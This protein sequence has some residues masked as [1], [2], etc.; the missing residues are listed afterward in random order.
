MKNLYLLFAVLGFAFAKAQVTTTPSTPTSQDQVTL[1]FDATGTALE[2]STVDLYAHTGLNINGTRW[3]NVVGTWNMNSTQPKFTSLGNNMYELQLGTS[4]ETFYAVQPG[5]IVSEICLVIRNADASAQTSPDIFLPVFQPGLNVL[6]TAPQ[7]G[8][9]FSDGQTVTLSGDASVSSSMT[10][11]VNGNQVA[12]ANAATVSTSY[13]FNGSGNYS[14]EVS[15]DDG[16]TQV[17]DQI[18]VFVPAA[19]QNAPL[20]AGLQNGVNENADGSVTFVLAAPLKSDVNLLAS[21]NSYTLDA[22]NQMFK[23]GDYFWLTVPASDVPAGQEF[24]YQYLV[25]FD[26]RVADPYS[27][28]ILDPS[29]DNE[30]PAGNFPNL[31]AYPTNTTGDLSLYTPGAVPYNWQNN[32]FQKPDQENLVI[33]ELLVRDFSEEDSFQEVINRLDYLETLGINAIQFMPLNE[34]ENND[35][36]GYNPKLHGAL[37]KVYGTPTKFKELVD[38]CHGRGIAVI[39]DVVYNHAYSQSPLAQMWWDEVAFKPTADNPYL[40]EDPKHDFNVGYDFNHESSFTREYVKQTLMYWIDEYRIDGFR[41]DLS[42]GFT[43]NNTLGNVGAWNQYDQSRVDILN[44]YRTH[45]WNNANGDEYMILE[46]L[47]DNSEEK[48]LADFG[49]MLWGKMTDEFNQ[50]SMG[51]SSNSDVFRSYFSSRNYND[52]HLVAYAE[53][54]DEQRL[55]YKNLEFGNQ[56]N[57]SHDVRDLSVALDRQ[58]AIAAILYS[59][60]GPKM[61]WQFGELG[62]DYDIDL[63]GRTGRKPIPWTVGYDTD[64]DRID[65]YDVTATM[66]SFKTLYPDTWNSTNNFLDVNDLTKRITL[67]GPNFDAVVIANF[68]VFPADVDPGFSQNG[69]WYDYFNGNATMNVTNPNAVI[70][71]QPGEYRVFTTTPLD[72]PLSNESVIGLDE[73]ISVYPN[74]AENFFQVQGDFDTLTISNISGQTVGSYTSDGSQM[75]RVDVSSLQTG[76]YLVTVAK[77]QQMTNMKVVKR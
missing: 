69:T 6:V 29:R 65:L 52:Q 70:N 47:A 26:I 35:S 73:L 16:T 50:N 21:F 57:G 2:N 4:L 3:Q 33:Y 64:Q 13:T 32:N 22:S 19:T 38:E 24:K 14:I 37:D 17:A 59:I 56:A 25:D 30:I 23:D 15:A 49:F 61:L 11:A 62:Y 74:P 28:L 36:W 43:Q 66:I 76:V 27:R 10:I 44:D 55:M 31:P 5:D 48:A 67:D 58:E 68:D 41:F 45:V 71:L 8:D 53:S 72:N 77:G 1:R 18:N 54:H 7:N 20:P 75:Q 9:I 51:F 12:S 42:K 63:N 46:H 60:P 40:N 39:L 34:F